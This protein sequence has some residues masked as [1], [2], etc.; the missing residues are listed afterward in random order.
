MLTQFSRT[1][2]VF[3]PE[4]VE[5]LRNSSVAVLGAGGVGSF[6]MEALARIGIGQLIL[7]D[8]D[9]VDVTN[10]NRQIPALHST[11]GQA[12]VEIMKKRIADIQPDC[13][14]IAHRIFFLE[15]TKDTLFQY[16]LDY[17]IDAIDTVSAKILLIKEC[18]ER[19]IPIV[20]SMG[21]ANKI[22]PTQFRVMDLS[23]TRVDPIA[24]VLRR[25][26][27]KY[28]I[29]RGIKTVCSL[30]SPK[31]PREDVRK[32]IVSPET[33]ENA[34]ARKMKMPPASV[35][36]VPSVAGLILASVVVHDLLGIGTCE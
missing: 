19:K 9:E 2:L 33:E 22:D 18:Y 12:K 7:I 11:I 14:V 23:K 5:R 21:A 15:E 3:G 10:I 4:G 6:A 29:E 35:S 8:R 20:S 17:V 25:E 27:R 24:K 36:Y 34:P 31:T 13:R 1:E 32:N 30:E 28:G 26:L 16:P